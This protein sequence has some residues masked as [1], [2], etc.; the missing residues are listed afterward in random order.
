MKET[1]AYISAHQNRF[2]TE[3]L[4]FLRI[5]SISA[6]P[7]NA[8]SV[9]SST[10]I[11]GLEKVIELICLFICPDCVLC[12]DFFE[13]YTQTIITTIIIINNTTILIIVVFIY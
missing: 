10:F 12:E 9:L 5:P 3:L 4:E 7:T 11:T 1:Q 8:G 6:D 13:E 2:L